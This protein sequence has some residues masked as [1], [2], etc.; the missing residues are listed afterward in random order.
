MAE[1]N[2][3]KELSQMKNWKRKIYFMWKNKLQNPKMDYGSLTEEEFLQK[4]SSPNIIHYQNWE[5]SSEYRRLLFLLKES[6]FATDLLE[7]YDAVK[8]KAIDSTDNQAIKNLTML[9]KEIKS[10][11]KSIDVFHEQDEMEEDDG[12]TV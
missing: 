12:L 11:R 5:R 8:E 2:I 10:Y 3:W 4:V 6:E 1:T 7:V 9:Q